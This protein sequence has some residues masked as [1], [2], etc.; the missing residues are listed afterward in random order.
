M[1]SVSVGGRSMHARACR[2]NLPSFSAVARWI[3][4]SP[5]LGRLCLCPSK[6]SSST[7]PLREELKC[8][9]FSHLPDPGPRLKSPRRRSSVT[10]KWIGA[11]PPLFPLGL[12]AAAISS[13]CW[14]GGGRR[15]GSE[16]GQAGERTVR[17]CRGLFVDL[18]RRAVGGGRAGRRSRVYAGR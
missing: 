13:C 15:S 2:S 8:S 18:P 16:A 3:D 4:T 14:F 17:R 5:T 9:K 1:A 7:E 6:R 11:R 10:C 12:R